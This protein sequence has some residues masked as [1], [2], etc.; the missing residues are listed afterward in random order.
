MNVSH[1]SQSDLP[2]D[3]EFWCS[4][5]SVLSKATF[6]ERGTPAILQ[7]KASLLG[8]VGTTQPVKTLY[9]VFCGSA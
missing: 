7:I 4:Q 2:E 3:L 9:D 1:E 5:C 8:T 6:C